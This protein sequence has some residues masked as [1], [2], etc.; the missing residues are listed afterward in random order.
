MNRIEELVRNKTV[1]I[2]AFGKSIS[3]LES[4]IEKF[5]DKDIVWCTLNYFWILE[6]ILEKINKRFDLVLNCAT[7]D[8]L[9]VIQQQ[10]AEEYRIPFLQNYIDK[11]GLV[12]STKK[13]MIQYLKN[14]KIDFYDR[15]KKNIFLLDDIIRKPFGLPNSLACLILACAKFAPSKILIFGMDGFVGEGDDIDSYYK[16]KLIKECR[17]RMWGHWHGSIKSTTFDFQN[18][19]W[20]CYNRYIPDYKVNI[21]NVSS[22]SYFDIFPK[23]SSNEVLQIL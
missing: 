3:E 4:N 8:G 2:I 5:R 10:K 6:P 19:F 23:L 1:G 13:F 7:F 20:D 14:L 15:N 22:E 9:E 11:N 17:T 12:L 18:K 21:L 16:P